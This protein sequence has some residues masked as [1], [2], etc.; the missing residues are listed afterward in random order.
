MRYNQHDTIATI[1]NVIKD[2]NNS[3]IKII[4]NVAII[5]YDN[6]IKY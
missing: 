4:S 1:N 6:N 2:K 5:Y 3:K